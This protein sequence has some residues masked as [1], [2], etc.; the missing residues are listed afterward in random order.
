MDRPVRLTRGVHI[1]MRA[2]I[3]SDEPLHG[4]ALCQRTG[5]GPATI[6]LALE[7]LE[8]K[9]DWL[10]AEWVPHPDGDGPDRRVYWVTGDDVALY[11]DAAHEQA[12]RMNHRREHG[13]LRRW[14]QRNSKRKGQ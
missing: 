11:I 5:K 1:V 10:Y 8:H 2:L 7:I 12:L 13:L 4:Y 3:D 6:Y 14:R 9:L